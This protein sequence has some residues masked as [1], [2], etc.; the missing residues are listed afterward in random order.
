MLEE[1]LAGLL[2][3]SAL[4]VHVPVVIP[5]SPVQ[6][7]SSSPQSSSP[8][9]MCVLVSEDLF[10]AGGRDIQESPG[11]VGVQLLLVSTQGPHV[12]HPQ[13]LVL[14]FKQTKVLAR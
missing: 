14:W 11:C 6:P 5:C 12:H 7:A 4:L 1:E 2:K 13:H 8:G 10:S 3:W 9:C